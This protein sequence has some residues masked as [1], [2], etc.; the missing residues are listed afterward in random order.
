MRDAFFDIVFVADPRFPGGTSTSL[1]AEVK[2]ARSA[3]LTTALKPLFSPLLRQAR[4][5]HPQ[6]IAD[7]A[8]SGTP[9]LGPQ[10]RVDC[11]FAVLHHPM[12]FDRLPEEPLR[13]RADHSV[14]VLHHPPYDGVGVESYDPGDVLQIA[15]A[16][17][18][19]RC[20]LA[21]VGPLVRD[22]LNNFAD[23]TLD[24]DWTNLIDLQ[25]WPDNSARIEAPSGP[26]FQIGRHSR[27][28]PLKWPDTE[29]M[30]LAAYPKLPWLS[31][32][33]LGGDATQLG[34][35]YGQVPDHWSL[36][37]FGALPVRDYLATL[38]AWVYF[39]DPKWVEAFGRAILEAAASGLPIIV[40][41]AFERV[42]GPACI[43][44]DAEDVADVLQELKNDDT[45]RGFQARR[46]RAH[47]GKFFAPERYPKRLEI[48]DPDWARL[49]KGTT[50]PRQPKPATCAPAVLQRM[51]SRTL[52]MSSNGVGL[53]H[54][55]R[56]LAIAEADPSAPLPAF[57]TL[58][59]GAG[60][61]RAAGFPCEFTPFHRGL[62]VDLEAWNRNLAQSLTEAADF[63]RVGVFVYDGNVPYQ[64]ILDFL[65][66]KPSIRSVWSRRGF[67]RDIHAA[68]LQL[69][70]AFDVVL[71]PADIAQ[72]LD[73]GPTTTNIGANVIH[74]PPIWRTIEQTPLSRPEAIS[75]LGLD[76]LQHHVLISLGSMANHDLGGLPR[77]IIA[78][79][80][81]QGRVP[82]LLRSP[83]EPATVANL[84]PI[85]GVVERSVYPILPMLSAFDYAVSAAGYNSFHEFIAAGLPTVWVPNDAQEMD[86]QDLR[87]RFAH[88]TGAGL[89]LRAGD[90]MS[91]ISVLDQMM[92]REL[93]E[94]MRRRCAALTPQNGAKDAARVIA[95]LA[96][97]TVCERNVTAPDLVAPNG[98]PS[99]PTADHLGVVAE[100]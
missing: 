67:W 11:R 78:A 60:F 79:V 44:A 41:K 8:Q 55:T 28:H 92:D 33:M 26:R 46:A 66:F 52:F 95:E 93:R 17:I 4:P 29:E 97:M 2:A 16:V 82:V 74:V 45:A 24:A 68:A 94:Q 72:T 34:R 9:I 90:D 38:D 6:L 35:R 53:G 48:L 56:L 84:A 22:Q 61:V 91:V 13:I 32:S 70:Q 77:R 76:P 39:H 27:P 36:I 15:D 73:H 18:G 86:R 5:Y 25:D 43:Y 21:P 19:T 99:V 50:T 1:A 100:L 96:C 71:H 83:L 49:R 54:L 37:D 65:D 7:L 63:H 20:W 89:T 87:A 81:Q 40:P 47:V 88:V 3:G 80:V 69:G 12:V 59:R 98:L 57:F 31:V 10:M 14:V 23:R 58:S 62:S 30:A 51:P 75:R 85:L 42:F 64:G